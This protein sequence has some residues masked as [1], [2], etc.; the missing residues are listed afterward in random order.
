MHDDGVTLADCG[1]NAQAYA[2]A[3]ATYAAFSLS[4]V[5]DYNCALVPWYTKEDRPGHLFSKQAIPMVWDY[6]EL[7]P[8]S[9]IGGS[10]A[11]SIGIVADALSGCHDRGA[12]G[13]V[14]Q[15]DAVALR[16]TSVRSSQ[17]IR[18]VT[19]TFLTQTSLI[20][21]MYGCAVH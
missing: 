9:E 10:L 17:P 7:N 18:R 1:V 15:L 3:V 12:P 4:K 20:F 2:D 16:T 11:A 5:A 8:I 21:S 19:I 6:A 13:H 14:A